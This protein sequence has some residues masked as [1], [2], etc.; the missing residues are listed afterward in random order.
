MDYP[1]FI[2]SIQTSITIFC[3]DFAAV[4]AYDGEHYRYPFTIRILR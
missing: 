2:N 1:Y 3:S 4:K